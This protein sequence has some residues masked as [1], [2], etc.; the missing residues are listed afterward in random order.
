MLLAAGAA[1]HSGRR[2]RAR[3]VTRRQIHNVTYDS[4][5]RPR[6]CGFAALRRGVAQEGVSLPKR[7]RGCTRARVNQPPFGGE[8]PPP[9]VRP[10]SEE[11][12]PPGFALSARDAIEVADRTDV[13]Q[14]ERA[15][16][17]TIRTAAFERADRSQVEYFAG[18]G[19]GREEVA[20][21]IVDGSDGTVDEAWHDHQVETPL[22]RMLVA[23][24]VRDGKKVHLDVRGGELKFEVESRKAV[25]AS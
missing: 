8:R 14:D 12:P 10:D 23:G 13:V 19:P 5:T 20:F 15:D 17:A 21:V 16:H 2:S 6:S 22:A 18:A 25:R 24:E 3:R 7:S 4:G 9:L 11:V 1:P